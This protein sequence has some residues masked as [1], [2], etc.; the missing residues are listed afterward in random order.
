M[1]RPGIVGQW[2]GVAADDPEF[3]LE[4]EGR[5]LM[6]G[7]PDDLGFEPCPVLAVAGIPDVSQIRGRVIMPAAQDPHAITI[8]DRGKP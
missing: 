8:D 6:P 3:V 4:N 2:P 5:M 1:E 7:L